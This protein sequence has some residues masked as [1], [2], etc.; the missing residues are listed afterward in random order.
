MTGYHIT[1]GYNSSLNSDEKR[2]AF[3]T[4]KRVVETV[5][6][7]TDRLV[8]EVE[9]EL[10]IPAP[11]RLLLREY[12]EVYSPPARDATLT[13]IE[14]KGDEPGQIMQLASSGGQGRDYKEQLR[15]AFSRL[16]IF[17]MHQRGIEVNLVV[18]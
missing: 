7:Q 17:E 18:A 3:E 9:R 11:D 6:A 13:V 10:G 16:V 12:A 5:R 2:A 8:A 14:P 4:L 15:R 1:I